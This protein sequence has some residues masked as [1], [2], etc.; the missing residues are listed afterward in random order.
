[1]RNN[2]FKKRYDIA[3]AG[4]G[5]AGCAAA[6]AAS[7]RGAK[8]ILIEKTIFAGGLATNGAVLVYLPLCDG[9]GHQV[10]FGITE[11]LLK[12]ANC[13]GP[14]DIPQNWKKGT[15]ERLRAYFSPASFVL[16]LDKLLCNAGVDVW[17]DTSIIG[18]NTDD[19]NNLKS[20]NVV[21]KSGIGKI[22]ATVFIDATGDC[23][24][25]Y[26]AGN[27]CLN[28]TNSL[29]TWVIEHREKNNSSDYTFGENNST[30]ICA[31]P[32]Q[33]RFTE[34]G[35]NGK[36][37]SDFILKSREKYR[38]LLDEDYRKG[39]EDRK[40]RFPLLLPSMVPLRHTRCVNGKYVLQPNMEWKSFDDS[41][42][43]AADWRCCGKVWEIPYSS[44][45]PNK[46]KN[47]IAAGRCT[48]AFDDAWEITR[49]IP[50]AAMTG[51]VAGVA[52]VL[53]LNDSC[54]PDQLNYDIL[55]TE[56]KNNCGFLLKH[57][58]IKS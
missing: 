44:M 28:A 11:E 35:I 1:M 25:A 7:R 43:L 5:V 21:N 8:T 2:M 19:D 4:A 10:S 16:A 51:E 29:V 50:V 38:K 14:A 42:G 49:V 53:S 47:L 37:V 18:A 54:S 23:D 27:E 20:L 31:D 34:P 22:E 32:I 57:S 33:S 36:I 24:V 58:G 17:F 40:T 52:A 15:G 55:A 9:N 30:L 45:L 56:L 46:V 3:I 41:I 6:L 13:Y 39:V 26:L 12:L 48:S